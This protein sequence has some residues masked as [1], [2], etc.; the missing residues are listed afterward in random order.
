MSSSNITRIESVTEAWLDDPYKGQPIINAYEREL[1]K[2]I[3]AYEKA[4]RA[5]LNNP[6]VFLHAKLPE[7]DLMTFGKFLETIADQEI[8]QPGS[9][10]S[11][12]IVRKCMTKGTQFAEKTGN[13]IGIDMAF[14]PGL[15][16]EKVYRNLQARNLTA[17]KGITDEMNKQI[18][19]VISDGMA[20]G[21]TTKQIV[22]LLSDR[23]EGIGKA[24][25]KAMA[26]YETQ[27]AIT[28]A[29]VQK[30]QQAG[31]EFVEWIAC[32]DNKTCKK[33]CRPRDGRIYPL[34]DAPICPAHPYC[35]CALAP[36]YIEPGE[37][38]SIQQ[39]GK[40]EENVGRIGVL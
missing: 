8:L 32:K 40:E 19:R 26:S 12:S 17:L 30:Y 22:E 10:V 2:L 15:L 18:V 9:K 31:I 3:R 7:F 1:L 14:G 36:V 4:A 34:E 35:R 11:D 33:I 20:E 21:K 37:D 27:F 24:R 23:V 6:P 39:E 25:A 13:R 5:F 28:T 29:A 38:V 16:D